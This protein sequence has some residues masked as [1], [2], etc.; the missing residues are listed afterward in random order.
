MN[1]M[2]LPIYSITSPADLF[3]CVPYSATITARTCTERQEQHGKAI[4]VGYGARSAR[5]YGRCANCALGR[6]VAGRVGA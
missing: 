2:P 3:R 1:L 5:D 4:P 6:D